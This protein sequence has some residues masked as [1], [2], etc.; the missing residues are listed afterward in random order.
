MTPNVPLMGRN[1]I[2]TDAVAMGVTGYDPMAARA[3]GPFPG[4]NHLALVAAL[5]LGT[6][7]LSQIEIMGLPIAKAL[8]PYG[9]E[10]AL[11]NT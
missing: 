1:A 2:S 11:R 4:D 8:D 5:G 7:D 6:N 3:T 9:W 10:P